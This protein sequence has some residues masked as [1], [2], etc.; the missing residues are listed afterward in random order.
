MSA[1]NIAIS[2]HGEV[3]H[4]LYKYSDPKKRFATAVMAGE[5][6]SLGGIFIMGYADGMVG[7]FD[8]AEEVELVSAHGAAGLMPEFR[9]QTCH[10][11]RSGNIVNQIEYTHGTPEGRATVRDLVRTAMSTSATSITFSRN[12]QFEVPSLVTKALSDWVIYHA[13]RQQSA[14]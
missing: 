11:T 10:M 9:V 3:H 2:R 1:R 5:V 7:L 6:L 14:G 13:A 12:A 8:D 4:V